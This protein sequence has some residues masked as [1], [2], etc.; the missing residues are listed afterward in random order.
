MTVLKNADVYLGRD[1]ERR[2]TD[3][4]VEGGVI[5]AVGEAPVA[6]ETFDLS[7]CVILPGFVDIHIHGCVGCDAT[8][9]R[10]DSVL[11]MSEWLV[12]KGVTSFCPTTMTVEK[13]LIFSSFDSI[14]AAMGNEPGAGILGINMEGPFISKAKKGAQ[15]EENIIPPDAELFRELCGHCPVRLVDIAPETEG[16]LDFIREISPDCVVSAA[17]T[18]VGY[19]EAK[20]AFDAGITHATHLF[21]AMTP[22]QSRTPG[23][24]GAVFDDERVMPEI[25]CDGIHIHPAVLRTA[26]KVLGED[27]TVVISDSMMAAGMADGEYSLGGQTV[28]VKGGA[29]TLADGTVAGSTTNIFDEFR[30]LISFGIPERQAVKSCTVNPARSIGADGKVGVIEEGRKADLLVLSADLKEIKAV[31]VNGVRKV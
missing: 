2:R 3:I 14:A 6:A 31:F 25:I 20:Q 11:K 13:S 19:D 26:F 5:T 28:Y 27:R 21:N 4:S 23:L 1:M 8:D 22:L 30:N 7:G 9:G 17:H 15:A 10:E 12:T 16:A 18:T 24:V 29:A